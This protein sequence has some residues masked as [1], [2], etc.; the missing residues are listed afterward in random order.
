[1]ITINRS[2]IR[3]IANRYKKHQITVF[4]AQMAYFLFLSIFPFIV[5]V[6]ALASRLNL[7]IDAFIRNLQSG[8]P[9]DAKLMIDDLIRNYLIN[10]SIT[11]LIVSGGFTFWSVSR[12]VNALMRSFNTA[13]GHEESRGFVRIRVTG[14]VV[15]LVLIV[16]IIVTIA[17]PSLSRGFFDYLDRFVDYPPRFFEIFT[18]IRAAV[19]VAVYVFFIL[20]IHK[21]LPAGD[22]R[23]M[24]V[25][26]GSA[27][28]IAGWFVLSKGFHFF[29]SLFTNYA[30][31][32]GGLAS[33]VILMIWMYFVST[34]LMLGAEIN[35]TI[36]DYKARAFPFDKR[37]PAS[38]HRTDR[39]S[40]SSSGRRKKQSSETVQDSD[41]ASLFRPQS[42][43]SRMLEKALRLL[44]VKHFFTRAFE[45]GRY[46][47]GPSR[48]PPRFFFANLKVRKTREHRRNVF[49]IRPEGRASGTTVLFLHGGGYING[50]HLIHW[51]FLRTLVTETR[52]T[53]V[54]PDYPLAPKATYKDTFAMVVP[55]CQKL[56][57]KSGGGN[58]V[59]MGDS[60]GGGFAL[61]LAQY[62][63]EKDMAMPSQIIMISP[64]LDVTLQNEEAVAEDASDPMLSIDGLRKV[65]K[66]YAGDEDP[67]D[68]RISP[69]NGSLEG[70]GEI[71][72]YIG[73]RE[74]LEADARKLRNQAEA[75]GIPI[76]YFEYK[77]M[78][79]D[80]VLYD[81]PESRQAIEQIVKQIVK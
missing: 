23:A 78:I 16:L 62:M 8:L 5:F 2:R 12:S 65:G 64:W 52:C 30:L 26:Y 43:Q 35:S 29:A 39:L 1:M 47:E 9:P 24:D 73:T 51:R 22:L 11:L 40:R 28:S 75:K 48:V 21:A 54:A 67:S 17:L 53:V 4:S 14:I 55:L 31:V 71:S 80:W 32:Y 61:A 36:R 70:L 58:V 81:L 77:D 59:L 45:E 27:F 42:V 68:P 34:V 41:S 66:A 15:T 37:Q 25:V 18:V 46:Q 56:I 13:Y 50:F 57:R 10:D 38:T 74:I 60:A 44:K 20:L 3:E 69:I 19:S 63:K 72:L 33:I 7:D 76:H 49:T 79:H 6:M